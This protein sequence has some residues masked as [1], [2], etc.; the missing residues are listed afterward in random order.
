MTH[1]QYRNTLTSPV[2]YCCDSPTIDWWDPTGGSTYFREDTYLTHQTVVADSLQIDLCLWGPGAT[3][4][5]SYQIE[6][7]GLYLWCLKREL[8]KAKQRI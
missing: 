3:A 4:K 7:L 5:L 8:L 2:V 1:P 6:A